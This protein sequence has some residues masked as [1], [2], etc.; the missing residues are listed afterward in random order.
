MS[1]VAILFDI[2]KASLQSVAPALSAKQKFPNRSR[3]SAF[4]AILTDRLL[5]ESIGK[6]IT[7][8]RARQNTLK[9]FSL[10]MSN[11]TF[12]KESIAGLSCVV[13]VPN[14]IEVKS[15]LVYFHGG[16]YAV[17]TAAGYKA[18]IATLSVAAQAKV[19]AVDYRRAP[20]FTFPTANDDCLEVTQEVLRDERLPVFLAGDSAGAALALDMLT[21][22]KSSPEHAAAFAKVK[23]CA[24]ISPWVDP[25]YEWTEQQAVGDDILCPALLHYWAGKYL[26][27]AEKLSSRVNFANAALEGF[28]DMYIQAAGAEILL[29]QILDFDQHAKASG[30]NVKLDIFPDQ[31]H[32]FQ[33]FGMF[34][35]ESR[36]AL[37]KIGD[38]FLTK[39]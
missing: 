18:T 1:H 22:L 8:M 23:A 34:A 27:D 28:P 30:V 17:G 24:L 9:L 5:R 3:T 2:V 16:G 33:T 7:W 39:I 25:T 15:T 21:Q 13:C 26:S 29:R 20:E 6:P 14:D 37:R 19:I 11:V 10:D 4:T 32:V 31:F 35:P 36:A 12:S 38:Y